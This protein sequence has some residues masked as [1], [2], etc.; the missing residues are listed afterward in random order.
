MESTNQS[1]S[2]AYGS[3]CDKFI[4][5]LQEG[6][7]AQR[8]AVLT[9]LLQSDL[10]IKPLLPHLSECLQDDAPQTRELA[11]LVLEKA[12]VQALGHL[13]QAT[14]EEQP[15]QVRIFAAAA[16]GRMGTDAAPAT[17]LLIRCVLSDDELL[18]TTAAMSLGFIGPAAVPSLR[19][20]L[21]SDDEK[22]RIAALNALGWIGAQAQTVVADLQGLCVCDSARL[23]MAACAAMAKI[24]GGPTET[25]PVLLEGLQ[26]PD[27]IVR[28]E[29]IEQI[30]RLQD[31]ARGAIAQML[32]C[33]QDPSPAV[34]AGCALALVRI[35]PHC[36]Q[37]IDPLIS[38]LQDTESAPRINAG[39]ALATIGPA[40]RPAVKR[41]AAMLN[42]PDPTISAVASAALERIEPNKVRPL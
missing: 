5:Q 1:N 41:L 7:V 14:A 25:L 20:L 37:A 36:E 16:L 39:I 19:S 21:Q 10:D 35:D 38:L 28:K 23:R 29:S 18:R 24:C 27:E 32:P 17:A 3:L 12:G 2:V 4:A 6:D 40:A 11:V 9:D 8:P 33:L 30:G 15:L 26:H 34:R 31:L 22:I 42:D 13:G